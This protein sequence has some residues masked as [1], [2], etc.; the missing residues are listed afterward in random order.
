MAISPLIRLA[1]SRSPAS[2]RALR[3]H[4]DIDNS[5]P[6]LAGNV[7]SLLTP[8]IF[9]PILSFA[10]RSPKCHRRAQELGVGRADGAEEVKAS[11]QDSALIDHLLDASPAAPLANPDVRFRIHLQQVVLHRLGLRGDS[12]AVLL[13]FLCRFIS[14]LRGKAY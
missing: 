14:T 9:I 13:C 1:Q 7:V 5:Y 12:L 6:M 11:S 8:T 3:T 4:A 10:L 2:H